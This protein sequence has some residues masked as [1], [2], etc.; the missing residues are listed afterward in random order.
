MVLLIPFAAGALLGDAFL[1]LLPEVA[2]SERGLDTTAPL[3]LL[4]GMVTFFVLEK[5]LHWHHS[6]LPQEEVLH[7]VAV[8]NLVGDA[9]HNFIDG[10]IVAGGFL[11]SPQLGFTTALVS[12]GARDTSGAG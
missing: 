10:A 6:H 11:V 9:L 12:C 2:E 7:P 5:M 4:G 1:H 3:F 8:S